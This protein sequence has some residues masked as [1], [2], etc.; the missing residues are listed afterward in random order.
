MVFFAGPDSTF[1]KKAIVVWLLSGCVLVFLMVVIGGITRL[2]G[3]GLSITEW[4]V[5]MGAIPPMNVHDWQLAF[6]K[7]QLSPQFQKVNFGMSL[8]EFKSIFLW[9]YVHRLTGR[10]TGIVF[11]IPFLFFLFRKKISKP[12]FIQ[13]ILL[14]GLGALQGFLGWFMVRSGLVNNPHVSHYRL[15]LHLFTAF[16]TFGFTFWIALNIL[17]PNKSD[18]HSGLRRLTAFLLLLLLLQ[19]IYG[20]LVAG[21]HAGLTYNTFPKM[22]DHWIAPGLSA[23]TPV[24]KNLFENMVCVQFIHR[25]I[26]WVLIALSLWVLL[27]IR[28]AGLSRIQHKAVSFFCVAL[29][30][31]FVLGV[32]TLLFFVPVPLAVIHQAGAFALFTSLLYLQHRLGSGAA[33]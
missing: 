15:A 7:Y 1:P 8:S 6:E 23:L 21:L 19:I 25:C 20:A 17:F 12:L 31:Q 24:W 4:N 26:A 22:G 32:C 3:S 28:N 5:I 10:I 9:E 2:T 13:L 11:L 14:F 18:T 27:K 30:M 16:I 29:G 33:G